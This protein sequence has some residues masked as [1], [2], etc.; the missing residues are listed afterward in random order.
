M[1]TH[2]TVNTDIILHKLR[3]QIADCTPTGYTTIR[4]ALV[5]MAIRA[6]EQQQ[7]QI[8]AAREAYRE[9]P[10][11]PDTAMAAALLKAVEVTE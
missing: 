1:S 2:T 6:L 7:A 5:Y 8:D 11:L 4:V 3:S 10:P 9:Q